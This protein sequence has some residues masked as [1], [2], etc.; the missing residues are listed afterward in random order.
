MFL[1][2][3]FDDRRS[4]HSLAASSSSSLGGV[5]ELPLS[6]CLEENDL[7]ELLPGHTELTSCGEQKLRVKI[8]SIAR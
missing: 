3:D 1:G 7:K 6:H 5:T 8:L 4:S 2:I